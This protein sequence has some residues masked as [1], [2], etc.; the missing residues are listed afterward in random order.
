MTSLSPPDPAL[1]SKGNILVVDDTLAN[2]R[3]LESLLTGQGYK[4]RK[5][6]SGPMALTAVQTAAPDLI[7]LDINM[8]Q[9]S[10]YQVCE[11]LKADPTTQ[12]IPVIFISALDDTFNKVKAFAVGGVD[13]I[14][15]PFQFEEV[16]ARVENQLNIRRMQQKLQ[17]LN[18]QLEQRVEQ[19]TA[20]LQLANHALQREIEER[21]RIQEQLLH[22]VLHDSLTDLPNRT[23]LMKRLEDNLSRAKQNR[24]YEFAVLFIDCDRFKVINDS[25]GHSA[26]D[27]LLIAV[28]R[29][30]QD[31]LQGS[32]GLLARL[33]GDEFVM[34]LEHIRDVEQAKQYAEQIH[35]QLQKPFTLAQQ[36]VFLNASVGIVLGEGYEQAEHLLRDADT[37]MYQAKS[38]GKGR[39][40][41]F[42]SVMYT[43]AINRLQLETDLRHAL[44]RQ[45]FFLVYQP[46]VQLMS[47]EMVGFE[48]L[49]R[50]EHPQQGRLSP[51][52]F[53]PAAEETGLIV[54][55]GEWVLRAACQQL[56]RWQQHYPRS[57]PLTMNVNLSA[58]QF[59]QAEL[60]GRIDQILQETGVISSHLKVE[61]T[62]STMMDNA[63]SATTT[64]S[65]LRARQIELCIDDF[66][67]G[68]SS[69]SYLHRF[70]VQTLK[71][72]RSFVSQVGVNAENIGI[73]RAIIALADNLGI[74]VVAEGIET[75]AQLSQ[76]KVLG[77]QYG[78]GYF[79]SPPLDQEAAERII[80]LG[81]DWRLQPQVS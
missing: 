63:E 51:A 5:V 4:V 59:A 9:M 77:C 73:V 62:E 61:I 12:G 54:P 40:Q 3:L 39:Y 24:E 14:P 29:R 33:G 13:Y 16:L 43:Q 72:D 8:P 70:P 75:A 50:W 64:L 44:E 55:I 58:R 11:R 22:R 68:Y 42:E 31:C 56:H 35:Q 48:A 69:L 78:Q 30:M 67:T 15:K 53:I 26:G 65:Q 27:Q 7:L 1:E 74:Q 10:G 32:L 66:G 49:I 60:M 25:L 37:A 71:I 81:S 28:A 19:R 80:G 45:E 23:Q 20:Q 79:F 21:K 18:A 36:D 6:L 47:G 52:K 57:R 46:L 2:L 17:E 41:V 76:L 38:S 34:L